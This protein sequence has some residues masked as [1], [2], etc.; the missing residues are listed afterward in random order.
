MSL[1]TK[2]SALPRRSLGFVRNCKQR[3]IA[4]V[5]F[6]LTLP[7]WIALLIGSTDG[8]YMMLLSQRVDRITYTV[9]DL[10]TQ[11]QALTRVDL[12]TML[13]A[14]GQLMSPFPF[15]EDGVVILTSLY[16]PAGG[17]TEIRW[18]HIGGG[19][20]ARASKI[21]TP[22]LPPSMPNG[23]VLN[24]NENVIVAEVY[25]AFEPMFVNAGVL[26]AGDM[27]R[28]AIYKPRLSPLITVPL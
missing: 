28:V 15:A 9:T 10:V 1:M 16:K 18:Q 3:G 14:A 25:Y 23:L 2:L 6:A 21:G 4:A 19:S 22:G 27:Y 24:D 13:L 12:D 26:A 8:A 20:L 7:I 5:E 17:T 11:S